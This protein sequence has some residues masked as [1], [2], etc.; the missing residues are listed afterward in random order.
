MFKK[1]WTRGAKIRALTIIGYLVL[2][3]LAFY[4]VYRI[5]SEFHRFS[6]NDR[7]LE[8]RKE[9]VLI[10]NILADLYETESLSR[11]LFFNNKQEEE[12]AKF[13]SLQIITKNKVDSLYTISSD[14]LTCSRLDSVFSLLDLKYKNTEQMFLLID[15]VNRLPLAHISKTT[16]LSEKDIDNLNRISSMHM[17]K[18]EDTTIVQV[19]KKSFVRRLSDVF[20]TSVVDSVLVSSNQNALT[21]DSVVPVAVLTDTLTQYITEI[22]YAHQSKREN[23]MRQL[24]DRQTYLLLT[25]ENLTLQIKQILYELESREYQ[26]NVRYLEDKEGAL[27]RSSRIAFRVA[28]AALV[29]AVLFLGLSLRI[30]TREQRYQEQ[31]KSAKKYAE[32]LLLAR[33]RLM[34]TISHDIKAPL[35]SIIG[36]LELL[37]KGRLPVKEKYYLENMQRS[38]EHMLELVTKLLDYHRLESGKQEVKKM[39]FSPYRLISDVYQGFIPLTEQRGLKLEFINDMEPSVFYQSDPFRIRQVLNNLLSNAVKFTEKGT[40][41]L[42]ASVV[43]EENQAVLNVTVRDTGSGIDKVFLDSIF[44]E[45]SRTE[46]ADTKSIEGSGLGL[47][48]TK[49][50]VSLLNGEISV[51]SEIGKG[52]EFRLSIPLELANGEARKISKEE[53]IAKLKVLFI[54]DDLTLLN[55]YTELLKRE[56]FLPVVCSNSLDALQILQQTSFDIVFSDIQMPEMNGFELVERIRNATFAG[57]KDVPVIAL[58]ARSDISRQK[59]IEAGFSCFLAKP[60]TFDQLMDVVVRYTKASGVVM[61][62][63]PTVGFEALTAFAGKDKTAANNIL[64]TFINENKILIEKTTQALNE[65]DWDAIKAHAHKLLPLMHMI[66]AKEITPILYEIENNLKDKDK[67]R[68]LLTMLAGKNEEAESYLRENME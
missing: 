58:S 9:L 21:V 39:F 45:F 32:D 36:Y 60:F 48:I 5:Y 19:Q 31:L 68:D 53:G 22:V 61:E 63:T 23:F 29:I 2:G 33:E 4:G 27:S 49:K 50:I 17:Q 62:S 14:P 51:R 42:L 35:S 11:M 37:A 7:P 41:S 8:E 38:S 1:K 24:A 43:V 12:K 57:A 28:L 46:E 66:G 20:K 10:S 47:A 34:L 52:S 26:K 56:G 55:M 67:V 16:V 15:S 6:E 59:F 18:Q 13:D 64:T 25:N 44:D 65:D 54:D 3:L 30:I 40:I